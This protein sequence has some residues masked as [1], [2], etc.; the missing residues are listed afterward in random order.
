MVRAPHHAVAEHSATHNAETLH[1]VLGVQPRLA[2]FRLL[3]HRIEVIA[4]QSALLAR[5]RAHEVVCWGLVL[6][7]FQMPK[8]SRIQ[9]LLIAFAKSLNISANGVV[10][11]SDESGDGRCV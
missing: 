11:K 2:L 1:K 3:L 9:I 4:K 10:V 7:E 6:I 5:E 8:V